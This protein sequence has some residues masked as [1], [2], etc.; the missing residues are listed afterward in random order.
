M[1]FVNTIN[2]FILLLFILFCIGKNSFTQNL[3]Y[4]PQASHDS[5]LF[6]IFTP[7]ILKFAEPDSDVEG[8]FLVTFF[9]LGRS[10]CVENLLYSPPKLTEGFVR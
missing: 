2:Y 6:P 10:L 5:L 1:L 9:T 3:I 4:F 7:A 8:E